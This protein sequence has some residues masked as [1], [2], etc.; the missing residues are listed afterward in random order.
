MSACGNGFKET[1]LLLID[2]GADIN[3]KNNV[4]LFNK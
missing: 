2:K 4:S 1:A 3:A